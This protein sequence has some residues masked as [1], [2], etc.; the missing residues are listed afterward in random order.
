MTTTPKKSDREMGGKWTKRVLFL[1]TRHF[2]FLPPALMALILA[3]GYVLIINP[4]I[5]RVNVDFRTKLEEQA[6]KTQAVENKFSRINSLTRSFRNISDED[7]GKIDT[8][9]PDQFVQ[10]EFLA[11]FESIIR[12]NGMILKSIQ[13]NLRQESGGA[14][15]KTADKTGGQEDKTGLPDEAKEVKISAEILGVTYAGLKNLLRSIE[16]S[17]CLMDVGSID[18]TPGSESL[19]LDIVAY[20]AP[21]IKAPIPE[22]GE[23]SGLD[24]FNDPKLKALSDAGKFES[25][26][27]QPGKDDIFK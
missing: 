13:L 1:V 17:L 20:Y 8:I 27:M 9:L 7:M 5:K 2:K 21:Q 18:Y 24:I 19:K 25:K 26:N 11:R 23:I 22:V 10:E 3:V 16:N 14:D 12:A 15:A 6:R 4:Q